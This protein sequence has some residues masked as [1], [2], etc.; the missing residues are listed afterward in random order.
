[1]SDNGDKGPLNEEEAVKVL[2]K[3]ILE[4]DE[5][6]LG[7]G[8]HVVIES[9]HPFDGFFEDIPE[10]V[11]SAGIMIVGGPEDI[12]LPIILEALMRGEL[13]ADFES[14]ASYEER[15]RQSF[16]NVSFGE[17]DGITTC[18]IPNIYAIV[19]EVSTD[20]KNAEEDIHIL[21]GLQGKGSNREESAQNLYEQLRA[22]PL[23][24]EHFARPGADPLPVVEERYR[25]I[26]QSD[27]IHSHEGTDLLDFT[28]V[29]YNPFTDKFMKPDKIDFEDSHF[30]LMRV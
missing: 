18:A 28:S 21:M 14:A 5:I 3:K 16:D 10:G 20:P 13:G 11:G 6:E 25:F 30:H 23:I 22:M 9:D 19:P 27:P 1:M 26:R 24:F 2:L 4:A 7:A 29:D 17:Y 12:P 15:L 8:V